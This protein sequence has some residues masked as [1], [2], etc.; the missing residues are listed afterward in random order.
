MT[1]YLIIQDDYMNDMT[2]ENHHFERIQ[3]IYNSNHFRRADEILQEI[4]LFLKQL[5][6][7]FEK[8]LFVETDEIPENF[9]CS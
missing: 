3:I 6:K 8:F 7:Y 9:L 4:S 5:A 2:S 1:T